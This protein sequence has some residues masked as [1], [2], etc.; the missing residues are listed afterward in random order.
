[1]EEVQNPLAERAAL[2]RT[3]QACERCR[4]LKTR[5][6]PSEKPGACQRLCFAS[7]RE[8]TCVWAETPRRAK[9][10]RGP[11]RILQVEQKIDGL[12]ASLTT[13]ATKPAATSSP[14]DAPAAT[15]Q[16]QMQR[17]L[18][19]GSWLPVPSSFAPE[20]EQPDPAAETS[21]D[22]EST[23]QYLEKLRV[24]HD[25]SDNA[26]M[27]QPPT[28]NKTSRPEPSVD[29]EL[30]NELLSTGTA[31][32]LLNE[33]RTMVK[34][35]P[36][37]P[38]APDTTAQQLH[39]EKSMLFL[40]IITAASWEDHGRQMKLDKIYRTEIAN[41]TIIRPRRTLSLVQ[42][43]LVYLTWY[44]FT[45]S[46]KT[47]QIYFMQQLAIGLALEIGLHQKTR[48][49]LEIPGR[50]KPPLPSPHMLRERQ[51]TYLGCYFLASIISVGLQKPNLL[52]Y[53]DY[54]A[55]CGH[56]LQSEREY[57]TDEIIGH[58]IELRRIEGQIYDTFY[59]EETLLLPINDSRILLNLRFMET[60]LDVWRRAGYN[61]EY[62]RLLNLSLFFTQ[63]QLHSISLRPDP[64]S[65]Q[66]HSGN[67]TQLN[68]LLSTLD[69][70]KRFLD[71]L[72]E[73][74][75]SEYRLIPFSEWMHL[76]H[77][78]ITV[79]RLCIP[80]EAHA[81]AQWDVKAAQDRVRLDM[82]LESLCYRMQGL[83]TYKKGKQPHPDFWYS[84]RLIMDLTRSWYCRKIRPEPIPM[85]H[86]PI[87]DHQTP[88]YM[89]GILTPIS[90]TSGPS[91]GPSTGGTAEFNY[92]SM[93]A[94][95]MPQVNMGIPSGV[96]DDH[97]FIST[98]EVDMDQFL[99]MRIWGDEFYHEMGFGCGMQY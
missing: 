93:T 72:L 58:L 67:P 7:K 8:L 44:H 13:P 87:H 94:S 68:A 90:Y 64:A 36:F 92:G 28:F 39:K 62:Q 14:E 83:T 84:M 91:T 95:N 37:V 53:S 61:V 31:D 49:V 29:N 77:I 66:Q 55:E 70:G 52:K 75:T 81:A 19:P 34:S 86:H 16:P 25:F 33:Y 50:P 99:D 63:L 85:T 56:N 69:A 11:S 97:S 38:L 96:P 2:A 17:P 43:V 42:S 21:R 65:F 51:R 32:S 47:Q 22:V 79:A 9:R 76:P 54:M 60:Q 78:L 6:L 57:P 71:A 23:Q 15:N 45:F 89:P 46:H 18:A 5:C 27:S 35:F 24:I 98:M 3:S 20:I 80:S 4:S 12:V 73:C 48:T 41:H 59:N 30:V 40:A 26:D 88:D 10:I 82:Y 74:P 1:M